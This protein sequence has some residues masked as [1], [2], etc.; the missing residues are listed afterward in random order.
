MRNIPLFNDDFITLIYQ[1]FYFFFMYDSMINY[2]LIIV[3]IIIANWFIVKFFFIHIS[4]EEKLPKNMYVLSRNN[5]LATIFLILSLSIYIIVVFA[6]E[7]SLFNN[8]DLMNAATVE[9][10]SRGNWSIFKTIRFTPLAGFDNNL[11]YAIT[12]NFYIINVYI[13]VKQIICIILM[14]IFFNF[15]PVTKRIIMIALINIVPSVFVVNNV[16]YQEQNLLIFIL[17]SMIFLRKYICL[18]KSIYL[19][20]FTLFANFAIYV[21]ETTIL[22]YLGLVIFLILEAVLSEKINIKSFIKPINTIK[23]MPIEYMLILTMAIYYFSYVMMVE[24][25]SENYIATHKNDIW[26]LIEYNFLE[27]I[28]TIVAIC[29]F[30]KK[31]IKKQQKNINV[32]CEGS[33]IGSLLI[34]YAI[35][36]KFSIAP[37][38]DEYKTYYLYLPTVFCTAYIFANIKN[39]WIISLIFIVIFSL[40]LYKNYNNFIQEEGKYRRQ[41][42]EFIITESKKNNDI[43]LFWYL[44]Y[45]FS[46]KWWFFTG[47]NAAIKYYY[48]DGNIVFKTNFDGRNEFLPK[49]QINYELRTVMYPQI[50]DYFVIHKIDALGYNFDKQ[51]NKVYENNFYMVYHIK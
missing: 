20:Y 38:P 22:F 27:L 50:N 11:I 43:E 39:K 29:C 46:H 7:Q 34:I 41:L 21:K 4:F 30:I 24:D 49:G 32:F 3:A 13:V 45:T 33:L 2:A 31:N 5:V 47:W 35:V 14:Y 17:L 26:Q 16:I 23:T 36:F 48:P 37:F 9:A 44:P 15:I 10:M 28:I 40:S 42:A 1:Y 8:F 6:G 19:L 25:S 51:Y 12:N 18:G